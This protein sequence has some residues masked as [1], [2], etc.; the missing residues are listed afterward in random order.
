MRSSFSFLLALFSAATGLADSLLTVAADRADALYA[1]NEPVIFIIRLK[2]DDSRPVEDRQVGWTLAK[3]GGPILESGTVTLKT[4]MTRVTGKLDEPG[5]L[6]CTVTLT[7]SGGNVV[8]AQAGAGVS[9]LSIRPSLPMPDDFA[10]FWEAKKA[11]LARVPLNARL[12]AVKA[13]AAGVDVFDL[14]AD[15]LGG[16]PVSGYLARPQGAAR[17]ALPAILTLHGA[18][19]FDSRMAA[20]IGW[21]REGMLALDINAHGLPN[22][23][24]REYYAE[25]Y[26]GPLIDYKTRGRESRDDFYFLGMFLRAVRAIDVL[27]AQPEWDGRTIVV[28]GN[29]QGGAQ[30]IAVAGIDNR[31]TF[32]GAGVPAM[33]DHSGMIAGRVAGWPRLVPVRSDGR[34]DARILETARYFDM[35]NFAARTRASGFFTAGFIDS[36]CP[37]TTVYAAYNALVS[38]KSIYNDIA[39][40]HENTPEAVARMRQ[41]IRDH[42]ASRK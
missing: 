4:G 32:F 33:C 23:R 42:V 28:Q 18:G 2:P 15:C 20:A 27:V 1:E 41:A 8:T 9:P 34:P 37:P 31:V 10:A 13:P 14:Q 21:A 39:A 3:D 19:V 35:V 12:T 7:E 24:P 11:E 22:G 6:R 30:A 40:G 17:K 16:A 5:F 36:T 25:L 29:S 38:P 26:K